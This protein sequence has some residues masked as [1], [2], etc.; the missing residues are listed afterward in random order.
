LAIEFLLMFEVRSK[1]AAAVGR[2]RRTQAFGG[3]L[4]R[5]RI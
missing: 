4:D 2:S 3:A 5:K 1:A